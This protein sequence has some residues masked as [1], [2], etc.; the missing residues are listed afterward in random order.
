MKGTSGNLYSGGDEKSRNGISIRS[1]MIDVDESDTMY[2]VDNYEDSRV[3][4]RA[5]G[6]NLVS[7]AGDRP[8]SKR[9]ILCTEFYLLSTAAF[10]FLVV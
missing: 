1:V 10:F 5:T 6:H 3:E 2:D 9:P 4:L 8:I 7:Y